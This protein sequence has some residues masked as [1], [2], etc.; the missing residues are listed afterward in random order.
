M[1]EEVEKKAPS[2]FF[3]VRHISVALRCAARRTVRF[4]TNFPWAMFIQG[5]KF[6]P[7]SRVHNNA[8]QC[9]VMLVNYDNS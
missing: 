8:M 3:D 2:S 7:D 5:A 4:L 9:D 1:P 6:I